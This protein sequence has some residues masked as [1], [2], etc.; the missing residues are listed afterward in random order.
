MNEV[1]MY[2]NVSKNII[3]PSR[4]LLLPLYFR[5]VMSPFSSTQPTHSDCIFH[6]TFFQFGKYPDGPFR[7]V[8]RRWLPC[9]KTR[10]HMGMQK[11][12]FQWH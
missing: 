9:F 11:V 1:S 10:I 5:H 2:R 8:H 12:K 3:K 4:P 7:H 6:C